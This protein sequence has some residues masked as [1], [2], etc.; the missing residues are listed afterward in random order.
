MKSL[1]L[2]FVNFLAGIYRW[3]DKWL[4]SQIKI[5]VDS[6]H[7]RSIQRKN[8]WFEK[9]AKITILPLIEKD[10][11]TGPNLIS[12]FR[13]IM[14]V[15][16]FIFIIDDHYS[17]AL[18]F[19]VFL[20]I[21]DAIDGP[22]ARA[23]NQ[24]SSLGEILDPLGDKLICA[25]VFFTL[26]K[27]YLAPWIFTSTL[28]LEITMICLILILSPIANKLNLS[29]RK[30]STL[31]GTARFTLQTIGYSFLILNCMVSISL[32]MVAN[33]LFIISLPLY[34]AAIISHFLSVRR[35]KNAEK[36]RPLA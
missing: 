21:L 15:P 36:K 34:L 4:Q 9:L 26:G 7:Q 5:Y 17:I 3:R 6:F 22:L 1:T 2:L 30:K 28:V 31:F 29:F 33:L 25:A 24:E 20:L 27:Q 23:L 16:L 14:S 11:V 8:Y 35:K 19:F 12:I 18:I 10:I 13:G 32:N